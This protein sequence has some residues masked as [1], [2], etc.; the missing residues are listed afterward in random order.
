MGEVSTIG[1]DL[2]KTVF[3][4][5]GADAFGAVLLRKKLRRHQLLT[6]LIRRKAAW[7]RCVRAPIKVALSWHTD[8]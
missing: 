3:R 2:A 4:V 8:I 5:H 1:V 6:F 7:R